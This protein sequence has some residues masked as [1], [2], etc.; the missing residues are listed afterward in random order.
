[1]QR[2]KL[3]IFLTFVALSAQFAQATMNVDYSNALHSADSTVSEAT[4]TEARKYHWVFVGGY[5]NG[6]V[7]GYFDPNMRRLQGQGVTA[8][9]LNPA[10]SLL[11][12][13]KSLTVEEA[14]AW[15]NEEL[16]KIDNGQ[17]FILVGHSQG[18][19]DIV[20]SLLTMSDAQLETIARAVSVQSAPGGNLLLDL[21]ASLVRTMHRTNSLMRL[22]NPFWPSFDGLFSLTSDEI[23][24][25]VTYPIMTLRQANPERFQAISDRLL[26]VA[27]Y[28]D[29][30]L[31]PAAL[32]TGAVIMRYRLHQISDGIG[33]TSKMYSTLVGR[34]LGFIE[35]LHHTESIKDPK[36]PIPPWLKKSPAVAF[37]DSLVINV[38]KDL[39]N[40]AVIA[41][42]QAGLIKTIEKMN[43]LDPGPRP[44]LVE[45]CIAAFGDLSAPRA[46]P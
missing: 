5:G 1:M 37:T 43:R 31:V 14:A 10:S 13:S 4:L 15:L 18:G 8:S 12:P 35:G 19:L 34:L 32:Q 22:V 25:A 24:R 33:A 16:K 36:T 7:K 17:P 27:S 46:R 38:I 23:H 42:E 9:V 3:I 6:D 21:I 11:N 30:L 26:Y 29:P 45:R 28:K 39:A 20:G 44:S 2:M 41:E 40:P